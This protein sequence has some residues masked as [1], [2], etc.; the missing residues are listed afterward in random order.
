MQVTDAGEATFN[1]GAV[2]NEAGVDSDFRV[3]SDANSHMLFV[4]GGNNRVG[5]GTSGPLDILHGHNGSGDDG[6]YLRLSGGGSLNESYGGWMRGYGVS[7]SGGYLELGVVDAGTRKTAMQVTAQGNNLK[8]FTAGTERL[9]FDY[10]GNTVFNET[11]VDSDFRVE[12]NG[13]ANMLFVDGGS[14]RV[15]IGTNS[16]SQALDVVGKIKASDDIIL[17]QTNGR[18]DYDG[19]SSSGALRFFSTSGNAERMRV[20]SSGKVGIGTT[21][22]TNAKVHIVGDNSYVGNYGYSTLV[23]EDTS[24]YAGLNLRNG[25]YNWLMR[26]DG[27]TNSLQIVSSSDASGPGT[28]TYAPRLVIMQAGNVGIGTDDPAFKLHTY[29]PTTNVVARFESGDT[30]VW[31]DLHDNSSGSYGALVGHDSSHLFKVADS[32]V[33]NRLVLDNS[34]NLFLQSA[35]QN[36][37]VFGNTGDD[38][39][40]NNTN[41]WIRGNSGSL[42]FN[43]ASSGYT[44]ECTG[45]PRLAM[46]S[47]GVITQTTA[48]T[49]DSYDMFLR[50][51]DGGDPGLAITRDNVVGFGIAVR[52]AGNDYADLQLNTSGQT[53]YTEEGKIRIR[54]DNVTGLHGKVYVGEAESNTQDPEAVLHVRGSTMLESRVANIGLGTHTP[55]FTVGESGELEFM[56]QFI[57]TFSG[58]DTVVFTYEATLWKSWYFEVKIASTDGFY[59]GRAGGYNNNGGPIHN[60]EQGDTALASITPSYSG[61]HVIVTMALDG[62]VHPMMKFKFACGGGEGHPKASRCKLV[63]NS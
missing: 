22:P 46:S 51:T 4:D 12:S 35:S 44:W 15:G 7:G 16:P 48:G 58:G 28:G 63:V 55:H 18:I 29:H 37:L 19:G 23:L 25:N 53:S 6:T 9:Q 43:A 31:I 42:E 34:G 17:N 33:T 14:N 21:D 52:A 30:Q 61:Q 40:V 11:S 32:N 62:Q 60:S 57:G 27:N 8:F 47:T 24:G 50:S 5:V 56:H 45:T 54:G 36:R 59:I 26:N 10:Q 41:N 2:F 3:E 1:Q 39:A 49:S 20:E 13:N 38:Y